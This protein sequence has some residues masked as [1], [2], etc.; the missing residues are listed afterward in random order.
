MEKFHIKPRLALIVLAWCEKEA[1]S[2]TGMENN[3][4]LS[5]KSQMQLKLYNI[6]VHSSFNRSDLNLSTNKKKM[7]AGTFY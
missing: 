5:V 6:C 4:D 7:V 1:Y 3:L 2:L